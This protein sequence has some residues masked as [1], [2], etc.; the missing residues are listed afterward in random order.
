MF[1]AVR[2]DGGEIR[3]EHG[4]DVRRDRDGA[5]HVFGDRAAH[6]VVRDAAAFDGRCWCGWFRCWFGDGA[7]RDVIFDVFVRDTAIAAR[8]GDG[9]CVDAMFGEQALYEW[10][11]AHLSL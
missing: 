1:G 4:G 8:A 6:G 10:G 9:V 11:E 7:A 5:R 3:F 2:D